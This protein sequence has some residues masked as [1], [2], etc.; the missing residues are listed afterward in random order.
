MSGDS[1][2]VT[3]QKKPTAPIRLF[4]FPH[5]GGGPTS[6]FS[7][8]TLVGPWIECVCVQYPGHA[9]RWREPALASVPELVEDI[10]NSWEEIPQRPFAFYGHSFGGLVA[11]ELARRL[12]HAEVRGPEW[13]FVGA[14][15]APQLRHWLTPIH[16]LPDEELVEAVQARYGGI[17]AQIRA[18]REMLNLF[19]DS[20][21][22]DLKAYENYSM[23]EE[24]A[25]AVPITAFAGVEDHAL[26]PDRLLGWEMQTQA[27][28]ELRV[29]PGGHFFTE[30][31]VKA[32][33]DCVQ[34]RLM[35][36]AERR[37]VRERGIPCSDGKEKAGSR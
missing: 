30:G 3:A 20:M 2:F 11:F 24:A 10:F 7:W 5:A 17:P 26:P 15:R 13:L 16:A 19:L 33:T 23:K 22:T 14:T 28:F 21:R 6:F 36:R 37:N 35:D 9:Q 8:N 1:L 18:D 32:V 25:L 4:C 12:R 27:E 34:E 29:M 31:N